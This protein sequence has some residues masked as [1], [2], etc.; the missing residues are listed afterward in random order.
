MNKAFTRETDDADDD[1]GDAAAP[2]VPAGA[3]NYITVQGVKNSAS[4]DL[5]DREFSKQINKERK[6]DF[7]LPGK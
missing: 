3:R 5:V 1:E 4:L 6:I 2:A 7:G